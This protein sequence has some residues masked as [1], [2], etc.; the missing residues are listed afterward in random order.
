[1]TRSRRPPAMALLFAAALAASPWPASAQVITATLYGVVH[2]NTGSILPG[3]TV[4]IT[5]QGTNL[6]RE[7]V[8]DERGEFALPALPPGPYAIKIGLAGFKAYNSQG[9]ALGAG[10]TVRQTYVLEVGSIEETVTVTGLSPLVQTSSTAQMQTMGT[11]TVREIPVSRRNLQNV[12]LLAPGVNSTDSAAGGGRAFRVNGIGDGG[13]AITVDGSSAQTNPENRGFGNYGGQN[14]IEILSVESVAEVQVIKGV[15]AAEY[16]G[17]IGGQVNMI[18]RSGTNQFHG[19]LLE[20]FQSEKFAARDPFLP[21]TTAKPK[22]KFNQFGGSLGGPIL[23]NRVL[24]FSTYEG[25]REESGVTVQGNVAT[26]ATRDRM[27]AALPYA[28]TK[29]VLDNMPQPNV[30]IND[31][32]GRYTDAKQLTRHD[33][34]FL[35]KVDLE[36]GKG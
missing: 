23:R 22:I 31:V 36:A 29:L 16:G 28:E 24:F 11:E 3:A 26:Q 33:N 6:T 5:H 8:S 12:I 21:A 13:S 17:S 20:N 27:L 18:T 34:T 19:S 15:L 10:Q 30:P 4:V 9:L 2:D 7:T 35:G 25:Y 14:Q 32:I 1:M